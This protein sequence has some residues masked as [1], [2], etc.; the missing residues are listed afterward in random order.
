MDLVVGFTATIVYGE[1]NQE[2][3][4]I[5]FF[6]GLS[7]DSLWL[8]NEDS[9]QPIPLKHLQPLFQKP[10]KDAT[11]REFK[12][13]LLTN[14]QVMSIQSAE[15]TGDNGFALWLLMLAKHNGYTWWS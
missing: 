14:R 2:T 8:I 1:S 7:E 3:N 10:E 11:L 12:F 9:V 15:A 4:P 13:E 6:C 5:V